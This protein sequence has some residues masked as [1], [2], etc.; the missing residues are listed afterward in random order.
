M[1]PNVTIA[2]TKLIGLRLRKISS[3]VEALVFR[4]VP[5]RLAHLLSALSKT[6]G[7]ADKQG[8]RLK[9]KFTHKKMANLIGC[10]R[11]TVSTER[12]LRFDPA[13]IRTLKGRS[14]HGSFPFASL[15]FIFSPSGRHERGWIH[16]ARIHL[17]G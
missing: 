3:R 11:E 6:D 12:S 15:G 9:A 17:D 10:S 13:M 5:A 1:H 8:I 16:R 2:L 7:V 4:D 14:S